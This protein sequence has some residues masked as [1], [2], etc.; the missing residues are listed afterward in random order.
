MP[1]MKT[2]T[3]DDTTFDIVDAAA[4]E[5]MEN[6]DNPH[7]VTAEQ[8][9]AAPMDYAKKVGNPYNLLDNSDFRN[10]VNQRG[11]T[12][13]STTGYTVDRWIKGNEHGT[14]T[15]NNKHITLQ[16]GSTNACW[17]QQ[18]I[19]HGDSLV[20]KT[21]T[22]A[23]MDSD[24][25]LTI[26]SKTI[27]NSSNSEFVRKNWGFLFFNAVTNDVLLVS[28]VVNVG[29]TKDFVWA[30]LYEGEYTA[31]TLPEYQPNGYGAEL[32][33]CMRYFQKHAMVVGASAQFIPI[34]IPMRVNPSVEF[35]AISGTETPIVNIYYPFAVFV[36][37][38]S[39]VY[40]AFKLSADL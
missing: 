3:I 11:Q 39:T 30:A 16:G 9:G 34:S 28:I 18:K 10:P 15:V 23:V 14:V 38:P 5:H 12:S 19:P 22:F 31:E 7:G 24:G 21:L 33:E 32:A 2:L 29:Q 40:G 8:A 26:G 13:H 35:S 20:G 1:D 36:S 27:S 25:E 4:R 6:K 17:F 37:C